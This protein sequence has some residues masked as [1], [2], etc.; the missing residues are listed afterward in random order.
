ML[1]LES[2]KE[3]VHEEQ[4]SHGDRLLVILTHDSNPR[5]TSEIKN[6][7]ADSGLN[8]SVLRNVSAY[9]KKLKGFVIETPSGW[10]LTRK[11]KERVSEL[12]GL[13]VESP[14][15]RIASSLRTHLTDIVD[16]DT[17]HFLDQSIKCYELELYRPAVVLSWVGAIS[18]LQDHI[19]SNKLD[20]FNGEAA[21]RDLK[22]KMAKNKDD[23]SRMKE[24]D[25]LQ[26]LVAISVIGKNVKNELEGC[27]KLRNGCGH[28]NS[29]QI[30]SSMVAAHIETLMLNVFSK[31]T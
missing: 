4:L 28:P 24:Y 5:L 16:S 8:D 26:V 7:A 21:K 6:V 23:L 10:E 15:A 31:F 13:N 20:D 2:I 9:L 29:L 11:G 19:I 22:W 12:S 18:L 17:R 14:K 27:L 25:F 1:S 30:G 3:I